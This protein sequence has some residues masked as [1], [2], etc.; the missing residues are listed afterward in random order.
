MFGKQ[1]Y[2]GA[3]PV[4]EDLHVQRPANRA[5]YGTAGVFAESRRQANCRR[6]RAAAMIE[7]AHQLALD[8]KAAGD[9]SNLLQLMLEKTSI[10]VNKD[11]A[12]TPKT[13]AQEILGKAEKGL[14]QRRYGWRN[15]SFKQAAEADPK[16][17]EAPLFAGDAEY[18]L[19]H[20]DAAGDCTRRRSL[21][22]RTG[23][24]RTATG[25]MR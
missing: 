20:Y 22:I 17:Y 8:A 6:L 19:K 18:K 4:Y 11:A 9:N 21:S 1:N 24:P 14:C 7:S 25:A 13:P 10:P 12:A 2:L 16:L 5:L 15:R 3:L 23:R